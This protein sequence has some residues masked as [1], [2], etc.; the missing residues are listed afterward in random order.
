MLDELPLR[1][2]SRQWRKLGAA[3]RLESRK[4]RSSRARCEIHI[5]TGGSKTQRKQIRSR[6]VTTTKAKPLEDSRVS[7][8]YGKQVKRRQLFLAQNYG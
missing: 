2:H 8:D 3:I 4:P 1:A 7:A 6:K 5:P